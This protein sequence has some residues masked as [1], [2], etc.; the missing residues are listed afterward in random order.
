[1]LC[2]PGVP[3][4]MPAT[5]PSFPQESPRISV[6]R[7]LTE[8]PAARSISARLKSNRHRHPNPQHAS[9]ASSDWRSERG[10]CGSDS[11]TGTTTQLSVRRVQGGLN[12]VAEL[13]RCELV[14]FY[15][16]DEFAIAVDHGGV[17]GM[18]QQSSVRPEI[19]S[20]HGAYMFDG[21]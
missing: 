20:E 6:V 16:G 18:R 13:Y 21:D 10:G 19:H 14:A 9:P 5:T 1:M 2:S 12:Q 4:S 15:V 7:G 11:L 3:R 8:S 17:Q